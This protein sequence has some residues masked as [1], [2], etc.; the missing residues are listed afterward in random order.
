MTLKSKLTYLSVSAFVFI[1]AAEIRAQYVP[2]PP[3]APFS[4]FVNEYLRKNDPSLDPWDLGGNIRLRYEV[5]DGF[6]IPGVAGSLDFRGHGADVDNNYFLSRIRFHLGYKETWWSAYLEGR[7]SLADGDERWAYGNNPGVPGTVKYQG[8]GP[9][10]D[11]IDLQ[12]AYFTIGNP[13]AFPL[14]LK[15]GRQEL[16]Y[17]DERLVGLSAWNNITRV[18]DAARLRW[19]SDWFT[20]DF[21]TS[22]V[23]IPE[24]DRFN[25][26]NAYDWFSGLYATST[27]VPKSNLDLYFLSRN[28]SAEAIAAEPRPQFA[29]PGA[30]D[31][32]T[33]GLRLKSKP[34]EL[35]NWDYTLEM[36]GQFG[37]FKDLRLGPD[38]PRL[39]QQAYMAVVQGGYTFSDFSG[40][41]RL[42]LEYSYG[43]GDS[44]P[45]DRK[46][47][48]PQNV[49][50]RKVV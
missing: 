50:T 4:G 8:N 32:F 40:R 24:D 27:N 1:G 18:F 9:E 30:R 28:A 16:I 42:A 17:G 44:D 36:A 48:F 15:I 41:P 49:D 25:V 38:A 47:G 39:D 22:H 2:P 45:T 21:F 7:S 3:P 31:I 5:K 34:S 33:A 37:N 46:L 14:S 20:A 10:S 35:G 43:S 6:A 12:Q 19:Q 23:V 29:Q 26:S 13:K 11:N